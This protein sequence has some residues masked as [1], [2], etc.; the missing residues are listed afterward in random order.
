MTIKSRLSCI[1]ADQ[2]PDFYKEEGEN[3]LAFIEAYYSYME[4][5]GKLT[6]A[7]QNLEDYR[8]VSTTLDE[9]L[10]H[11]QETLLPSVPYDVVADKRL[12]AKYIKNYN[13]TRGTIASYKLLFRAIYNED[14]EIYYPADQ[15]LKVSDGDWNL[16]RY[17]VTVFDKKLYDFIGKTIYGMQSN[18]EALVEDIVGRV[19]NGRD[20]MQINVSNVKGS[21]N[22]Q[23]YIRL[24]T[25]TNAT[26]HAAI[27][28][29][30]I[31]K[32]EIQQPGAEYVAGD[33]IDII[34][35]ENGDFGKVVVTDTVDL[36][37]SLTFTIAD[38]GSGYTAASTSDDEGGTTVSITGGDGNTPASFTLGLSD[39]DDTFVISMNTNLIASNNIFGDLAPT[40]VDRNNNNL[41][42]STFKDTIIGAPHLGFPE[43][44]ETVDEI[45]YR[46]NKSA[47]IHIAN[48][49]AEFVNGDQIFGASG[50]AN[51]VVVSVL[52]ASADGAAVLEV[53]TFGA[54]SSSIRNMLNDSEEI[55]ETDHWTSSR[56]D[57]PTS[58]DVVAPDGTTTAENLIESTDT[59]TDHYLGVKNSALVGLVDGST[60]YTYSVYAKP[61]VAGS[62]RYLCYRGL[63]RGANYPIFDI[64]D[65]TVIHA[66]T[67]WTD[68]K[69]EPAGNGW[70]RC[71]SRT[72]PNSTTGWRIGLQSSTTMGSG[73]YQY[74]G[75]GVSGASIWGAQQEEGY[76][77]AYQRKQDTDT[78]GTGEFV[79]KTNSEKNSGTNMGKV[80]AFHANT[81]GYH[82]V[83]IANVA[84]QDIIEGDELV[85][86]SVHVANTADNAVTGDELYTFGV[87]KEIL[88]TTANAYQHEP[89][90][91]TV[92]TGTISSSGTTVT[93]TNVGT[94]LAKNEVI[95]SGDQSRRVASVTN[96]GVIE[97]DTAFDPA[98]SSAPYGKGGIWRTLI[99]ARV[100]SNATSSVAHQFTS[101]PMQSFLEGEAVRIQ[102]EGATVVANIAFTTSNTVYEN[103]HT[104]LSDSLIFKNSTFGSIITLSNR[105]GGSGF[106]VAP[107]V[108]VR[109][110]DIAALGIGEQY[111]TLQTDDVNWNT[112]DSQVTA[113]DTNDR[114]EQTSSTATGDVKGGAI[115]SNVPVTIAHA[116]GTYETTVRVW[117]D[118]LQRQPGNVTFDVDQVIALK[119]FGESY[120]PGTTDSRTSTG[121]G[122]AKVVK[123]VD[124][125]VLGDNADIGV[126]VGAD[127]TIT[128]LRVVDSGFS[129]KHDEVVRLKDSGRT[130]S[131]QA[132]VKLSL[133][134]VANSEGYYS[135][136]RSHLSTKRGFIQDS[137][138]YQE[139]SYEISV[140]L[141]FQR[142]KDVVL[143]LA[144]PA[145]QALF[146]QYQSSSEI[147]AD[148]VATANNVTRIEATGTF[149]ID[150]GTQNIVG[151][152][153]DMQ[154][155]FA[156]GGTIILE[157]SA[158]QYY[159]LPLNIVSSAIAA[160][161]HVTWSNTSISSAK[162]YYVTG[163]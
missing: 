70:W 50:Y 37:G 56:S 57:V 137:N 78:T 86:T 119:F 31:S 155:E 54:F 136:S 63:S 112:G 110:N 156:S 96:S 83:S 38:G 144:H 99:K 89:N 149:S 59:S 80:T 153:S 41:L 61:I 32:I 128:A 148:V 27:V 127:G 15:M 34:S 69:I 64:V 8:D 105:V 161:T 92:Q 91:N 65:G 23:E 7:I 116:N 162:A 10:I 12:L 36:G 125:G 160:T 101:G 55:Q 138:R 24:L 33:I 131:T 47:V 29:A 46:D 151:V 145:G 117:Q 141:S 77:T 68:T 109:E 48:T 93:G 95:K 3:F 142:Y 81:I 150:N 140:P 53:D 163:Q 97:T 159:R 100:T 74:T 30:G 103:I 45:E 154:N 82:V 16:D 40:V 4:Q 62:K 14:V 113:L 9:Y 121:T 20:L 11:F 21:F 76:L 158:G 6:D 135:S 94:N 66:G 88:T 52:A 102:G 35:E 118:F 2:F 13:T 134:N 39:I 108:L 147:A 73:G 90:A 22:H 139:F 84:S 111:I 143:Q 104:K 17:L 43:L 87:I 5:N 51:G 85:G 126:T 152:G 132:V 130:D 58:N 157:V 107:N 18:A 60:Y 129:H 79:F 72:N 146:G 71:S 49:D 133:D 26:G 1:V 42:M 98:L 75:D 67:Q 19:V 124:R 115:G 106:T 122:S 25:D 44:E 28:E 114:V 123:I 120:V